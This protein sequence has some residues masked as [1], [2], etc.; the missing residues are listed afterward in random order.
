MIKDERELVQ[1][2]IGRWGSVLNQQDQDGNCN[3]VVSSS[4][5]CYDVRFDDH[6]LC[7]RRRRNILRLDQRRFIDRAKDKLKD[8]RCN[9]GKQQRIKFKLQQ[10]ALQKKR[11]WDRY[12]R[13]NLHRFFFI[14]STTFTLLYQFKITRY[15][16]TDVYLTQLRDLTTVHCCLVDVRNFMLLL[17]LAHNPIVTT[18]NVICTNFILCCTELTLNSRRLYLHFI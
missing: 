6:S 9:N 18:Q 13:D 11:E 2:R 4:E 1:R 5:T 7:S 10:G 12:H 17:E 14:R 16:E 3:V 8:G 15:S